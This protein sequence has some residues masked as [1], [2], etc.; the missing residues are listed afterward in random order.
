MAR[1]YDA[2]VARIAGTLLSSCIQRDGKQL[3]A[4]VVARAVEVARAI[5]VEVK[6][7]EPIPAVPPMDEGVKKTLDQIKRGR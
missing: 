7:T 1:D 3:R 2:T 6:R 4:A 5:V